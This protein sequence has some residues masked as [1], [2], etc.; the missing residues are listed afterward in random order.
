MN[1]IKNNNFVISSLLSLL[2][3]SSNALADK[4]ADGSTL[5]HPCAGCHGT[6]GMI[7]DEAFM[8]LAGMSEET[9]IKTMMDFRNDKRQSTLM[10][11][12]AK[13]YSEEDIKQMAAFFA[14][15]EITEATQAQVKPEVK[16]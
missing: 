5:A 3:I 6:N 4:Q 8:P 10:G 9:F 2:F 11:H 1:F 12:V 13:G 7:H 16:K 15:V 14:Q